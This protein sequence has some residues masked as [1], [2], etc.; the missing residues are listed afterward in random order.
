MLIYLHGARLIYCLCFMHFFTSASQM[1]QNKQNPHSSTKRS[2]FITSINS[3]KNAK[4]CKM[5]SYHKSYLQMQTQ[6]H[7]FAF[8]FFY[9]QVQASLISNVICLAFIPHISYIT[10][11]IILSFLMLTH[12]NCNGHKSIGR[13]HIPTSD[14]NKL[15]STLSRLQTCKT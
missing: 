14:G 5:R 12:Q 1:G 11:F 3:S 4:T 2:Y 8:A 15:D 6:N 10:V 13:H 7:T 9:P